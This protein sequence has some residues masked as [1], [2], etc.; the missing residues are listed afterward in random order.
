ML[1]QGR[2]SVLDPINRLGAVAAGY[3]SGLGEA[4]PGALAVVTRRGQVEFSEAFGLAD[5]NHAVPLDMRS[6]MRVASQT[7]QFTALLLLM[8]EADGL[9]RLTDE[10]Q[11]YLEWLPKFDMP[12]TL[13]HLVTNTSGLWDSF[14]LLTL[15]GIPPECP[16]TTEVIR[17]LLAGQRTLNFVP[18]S[19]VMYC[20]TGFILLS[21][22]IE[23]VTGRSY[24]ALLAEKITGPLGMSDTQLI[25]NDAESGEKRAAHYSRVENTWHHVQWGMELTGEGGLATSMRDLLIWQSVLRDPPRQVADLI[26]AMRALQKLANGVVSPYG[27][28][29]VRGSYRGLNW[30]GHGG[31]VIGARS[32]SQ[33]YLEED[34]GV[35][36]LANTDSISAT[37]LA[38]ELAEAALGSG[39]ADTAAAWLD[40]RGG[41]YRQVDGDDVFEIVES[42]GVTK[43]RSSNGLL[44]F[45]A[46]GGHTVRPIK[47]VFDLTLASSGDPE[48]LDAIWCGEARKYR[49]L[50]LSRTFARSLVGKFRADFWDANVRISENGPARHK[51]DLRSPYGTFYSQLIQIDEDMHLLLGKD[52]SQHPGRSW[53]GTLKVEDQGVLIST[54]R[55]KRIPFLTQT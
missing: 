39:K 5:I 9:L 6:I 35:I 50:R 15:A 46:L 17:S 1:K 25:R 36:V 26:V 42:Q 51:L 16:S 19:Q 31:S 41:L 43:F 21:D 24:E 14:D 45:E 49:R 10:V 20:N 12:V 4:S 7:K 33:Y 8:L 54:D 27:L 11:K 22:V 34:L 28:G 55:T 47:S 29:V 38:L 52:D 32:T 48:V 40:G 53:M 3:F 23:R 44:G 37:S 30:V 18:G 13:R 2:F